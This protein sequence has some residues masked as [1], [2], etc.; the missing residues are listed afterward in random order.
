MSITTD[1]AP[2]V[3]SETSP[4][5]LPSKTDMTSSTSE[6]SD[7]PA[8]TGSAP[9]RREILYITGPRFYLI[10]FAVSTSLFLT[11]FEIPVVTTSLVPISSSL[12][13]LSLSAW[14]LASYLLG[15]VSFLI[16][17]AK[18]SDIFGR[19]QIFLLCLLLFTIFSAGCGAAQTMKQLIVLR[20]F[21]G[22]S[23]GGCFSVP[24]TMSLEMVP[25]EKF[26]GLT[27]FL[28]AVMAV[29]MIA[30]PVV[31]GA[32]SG[33]GEQGGGWRWVFLLNVPAAIPVLGVIVWVIPRGFPYHNLAMDKAADDGE[34]QKKGD[35]L[36]SVKGIFTKERIQRVDFFGGG[37]LLVSTLAM[38]AAF[39][40]AGLDF[41]WNSAF[42]ITL[43][44]VSVVVWAA[45]IFWE[46]RVTL[47]YKS[48]TSATEPVFPWHFF[49][50]RVWLGMSLAS[51]SLGAVW[52]AGVY[53]LPQRFMVLHGLPPLDAGIR[54][55]A[56][57]GVA[58]I[59]SILTA[60]IAKKGVPPI[61]IVLFVSC[62]QVIGFA[63]LGSL[64]TSTDD[65][66]T[67]G[68]AQYGY[69]VIAGFGCGSN[70]SLLGLM[71]P[72]SVKEK[73]LAVAMGA[74]T[75]VRIMGSALGVSIVTTAMH[76]FLRGE[77][78]HLG[79]GQDV[80]DSVL[81]SAGEI[82][83]LGSEELQNDVLRSF[84]DGYN[85]QMRILAGLAAGQIFGAALMWKHGK[86]I[87]V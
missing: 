26:A 86:Q 57:T 38:V 32:I 82:G 77:L 16:I 10:V 3:V 42:V 31:G 15:Y 43:L 37:L 8:Q 34:R 30:G 20:A 67:I 85:L 4:S 53:Q 56:Y 76:T 59:S 39:E 6:D 13:H 66:R 35:R 19:K 44:C 55:M 14:V 47:R 18:L 52:V 72:F 33:R 1:N 75:Q 81:D 46:R 23:G 36:Q 80:I 74:I 25:K 79:L 24:L 27:A 69:Q 5:S 51:L 21:Q 22:F 48:G 61:Y 11:N 7:P 17:F 9:G 49:T 41:G 12:G 84:A 28:S 2:A 63:L 64:S 40:E 29:S 68:S 70:I 58:P 54:V 87:K 62:L 73:D 65:I 78:G 83:R 60:G 50:D 71:T 45:F